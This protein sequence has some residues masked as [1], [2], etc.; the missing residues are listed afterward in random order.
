MFLMD[1]KLELDLELNVI[2]SSIFDLVFSA[3]MPNL[4]GYH[5]PTKKEKQQLE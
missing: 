5:S 4:N 3:L 1:Q 2:T